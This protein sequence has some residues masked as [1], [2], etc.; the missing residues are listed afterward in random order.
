M[1][2]LFLSSITMGMLIVLCQ[3]LSL[4]Q[5]FPPEGMNMPG[6]YNGWANPPT[7]SAFAGIQ[8]NGTFLLD[9]SL[10][11]RRYRTRIFVAASGGD[12]TGGT[13]AWLFT[14]GPSTNYFQNKWAGTTVVMNTVQT[15]TYNSGSDNSVTVAN[16]NYYTVNFKD[17]GYSNSQAV[18]LSTSTPPAQIL[19]VT[20]SPLPGSV[21]PSDSVTIS[22]TLDIALS[23]EQHVY[24]R[25]TTDNWATSVLK[26]VFSSGTNGST[27]LPPFPGGTTVKYYV[28]STTIVNP[29]SDFDMV[30][31]NHNN[32]NKANYSYSVNSP[33]YTITATAGAHGT[34][35]PS[36]SIIVTHGSDT[37]FH[38][39]PDAGYYVA[40]ILVDGVSVG[41]DTPYVFTNVTANHTI[42]AE[43]AHDV[44]VTV[45][46][47]MKV[48][49]LK[50]NFFPAL[51]DVVTIRGDFNDWGN[52]TN[53]PDT[54]TD[55]DNDS[56]YTKTVSMRAG[57]THEYKFWKSL[58]N[59]VD[60]E[61]NNNRSSAIG[62]NDTTLP[63][64]FFSNDAG[65][66]NVTFQVDMS[67]QMASGTFRPD[68]GDVVTVRGSFNDWGNSTNNPDTLTD[69]DN[70]SIYTKTLS[71][72]SSETIA[73]K[74]WKT[75][76][77]GLDYE[78]IANRTLTLGT[79]DTV[80]PA[81]Y[82]NNDSTPAFVV[83]EVNERWN[84]ISVPAVVPDYRKSVLFPTATSNAYAFSNGYQP[85]DTLVNGT[86]YWLKFANADTIRVEG[87]PLTCVTIH[88]KTGW[89]LVGTLG[90]PVS[91]PPVGEQNIISQFF[92]YNNGYFVADT[93][94]PGKSYW[95]KVSA[96]GELTLCCEGTRK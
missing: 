92:G 13:Y 26:E 46:V 74:F 70:D 33:T 75:F 19:T 91:A 76:R 5:I 47:N 42:H 78:S 30:T 67:V 43:F 17:N 27:K 54:L 60:Y 18:W 83:F 4:G 1:T 80:L 95:V 63:V 79:N 69:G 88:V 72:Q 77:G 21:T 6:S 50:G 51:G 68:S 35:V 36:G 71:L 44:N 8:G 11:T 55:L 28:M 59:G 9:T 86:G 41:T 81:V 52:S 3:S 73:Y 39:T 10:A 45:G 82:F 85:K 16:G 24:V 84:M 96:D 15:Y 94:Y 61:T 23:A 49:M 93:L 2:K 34:I 64:V 62:D 48:Q 7:I 56:M 53:N 90:C 12:I 32:N 66:V 58:R 31:L 20:Q 65:N 37:T 89:N 87:E 38:I 25:Y 57:V 22:T 29:T 14:S 40:D